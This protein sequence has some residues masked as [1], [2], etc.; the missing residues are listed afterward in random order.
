MFNKI[1]DEKKVLYILLG[2]FILTE[3]IDDLLDHILGI[4]IF[5]SALQ[6]FM[7]I[8]LFIVVAKLYLGYFK[9]KVEKLIPEELR[10]ILEI[11]KSH[12]IKGVVVNLRRIGK[13]LDITKPTMKKRIDHL[14]YLK[15]IIVELK[16][17][18]KYVRLTK[19]GKSILN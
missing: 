5:H 12:E 8:V 2:L 9:K 18:N 10:E 16:G 4:S 17:N 19:L 6:F 15:Y 1:N 13:E 7:F 14:L 11:V 3:L